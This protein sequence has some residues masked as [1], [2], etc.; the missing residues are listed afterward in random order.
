MAHRIFTAVEAEDGDEGVLR[1]STIIVGQRHHRVCCALTQILRGDFTRV[2]IFLLPPRP[3]NIGDEVAPIMPTEVLLRCRV[4]LEVLLRHQYCR[5]RIKQR[6]LARTGSAGDEEALAGY[7]D[8]KVA[9]KS[10]PVNKLD[11]TDAELAW[12]QVS[13]R[14]LPPGRPRLLRGGRIHPGWR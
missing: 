10:T 9:V 1:A 5:H 4:E 12:I 13:H 11:T 3:A 2:R 14:K 8:G 6:G 7:R